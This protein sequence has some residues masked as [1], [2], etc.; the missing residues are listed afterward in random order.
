MLMPHL[1]RTLLSAVAVACL[2]AGCEQPEPNA[3]PD[4]LDT[5]TVDMITDAGDYPERQRQLELVE[6]EAI[7]QCMRAAGFDWTGTAGPPN[8]EAKY[9]G[10]VSM[11]HLRQHGYGLSD[12]KPAEEPDQQPGMTGPVA[13]QTA[14]R[15][16][17]LGPDGD[18]GELISV[19]G[20]QY[21]YPRQGC[22]AQSA[23]AFYG[24]LDTWARIR[25][26]PGEANARLYRQ[27][28][29]DPRYQ[30][31]L[32]EWRACMG[33]RYES[34]GAIVKQ[35]GEEYRTDDR[36]LEQRRA[37]EIKLA[38]EDVGCNKKVR[39]TVTGLELRREFA[40]SLPAAD[41]T[42]LTR[43]AALFQEAEKRA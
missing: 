19:N 40:Q 36:P 34:P 21:R 26:L 35:L 23:E 11:D 25:Y 3:A 22:K 1:G 28:E 18:L 7:E 32:V 14:L 43:L 24:D 8:P 39:L 12:E 13:G 5:L 10:G 31:K 38:L 41:R 17:L 2:A 16:A 37:A 42:E 20:A 15:K 30:A 9:G 6:V 29:S 27:A 4:R 33:G